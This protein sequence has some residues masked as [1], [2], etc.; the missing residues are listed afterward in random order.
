MDG[1]NPTE[2]L[3]NLKTCIAAG[4]CFVF[5]FDVYDGFESETVAN[6]GVLQLPTATESLLG[7]HAVM[8][9]GYNDEQKRFL[10]KNSWGK[11]WGLPNPKYR[12]YFTMPYEYITD[13]NLASDFWTITR[14][15]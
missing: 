4:R 15:G 5:G 1:K 12:G 10:V 6:T 2:T 14:V 9:I 8:A 11:K 13:K 7:G 3:T